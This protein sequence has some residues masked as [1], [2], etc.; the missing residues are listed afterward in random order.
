MSRDE[1]L[2][3][4]PVP[5]SDV[6][7]SETAGGLVQLSVP[8]SV[9][10]ALAGLAR[11]LG[12]WDGRVLRKTVELDA[13]GTFVWRMINGR[14]TVGEIGAALA[15][16]YQ[17]NADEARLAVAEF[18]RQLGRRGAVAFAAPG[19]PSAPGKPDTPVKRAGRRRG[20]A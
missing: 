5:N 4:A 15:A 7:A 3:L 9:R 18:L 12:A 16:R 13:V 10:P 17:L 6:Q 1:A 20:G 11:R 19:G 8:V 14:T 2:A